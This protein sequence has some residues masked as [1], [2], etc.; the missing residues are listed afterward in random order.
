MGGQ[1]ANATSRPETVFRT[2]LDLAPCR[3]G[4]HVATPENGVVPRRNKA[5]LL[6]GNLEA[7]LKLVKKGKKVTPEIVQD[8]LH[9][10]ALSFKILIIQS[11]R[12]G[13]AS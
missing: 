13:G 3:D 8:R 9:K 1:P 5:A 10:V 7:L 4:H 2:E 11:R 6:E 12:R